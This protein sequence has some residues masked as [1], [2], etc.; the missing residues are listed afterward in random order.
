M[1]KRSGDQ[2]TTADSHVQVPVLRCAFANDAGVHRGWRPLCTVDLPYL[3]L[4]GR[5]R[6]G[7]K[8]AGRKVKPMIRRSP[9]REAVLALVIAKPGVSSADIRTELNLPFDHGRCVIAHHLTR[10]YRTGLV[11]R[12]R[13]LAQGSKPNGKTYTYT[14]RGTMNNLQRVLEIIRRNPGATANEIKG[15]AT[16]VGIKPA[17]TSPI[18]S[19]LS[20][21]NQ[22]VRQTFRAGSTRV[23]SHRY[24]LPDAEGAPQVSTT[25]FQEPITYEKSA[26]PQALAAP[27]MPDIEQGQEDR[28]NLGVRMAAQLVEAIA[29]QPNQSPSTTNFALGMAARIKA[30]AF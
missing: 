25:P 9:G 21:S 6:Q 12:Q 15:L 7:R 27:S 18:L 29:G 3:L 5:E 30:M 19:G 24:W 2:E 11:D 20:N 26:H 23:K 16:G 8:L 14:P 4:R 28:F 22:V 10:L 13:I 1:G 17:T